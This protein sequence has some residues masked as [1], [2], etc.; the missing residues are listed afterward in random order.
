M[1]IALAKHYQMKFIKRFM[2]RNK[3]YKVSVSA[4]TNLS[5]MHR[6]TRIF[7]E[8]AGTD[9]CRAYVLDTSW[10]ISMQLCNISEILRENETNLKVSEIIMLHISMR[11]SC[12]NLIFD[13]VDI[14]FVRILKQKTVF[15]K[16]V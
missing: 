11:E 1:M 8:G 2:F 9:Y 15:E 7:Y 13:A 16:F 5:R 3:T 12:E 10:L 4:R 14:R 6:T